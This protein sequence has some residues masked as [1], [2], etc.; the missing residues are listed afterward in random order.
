VT[1]LPTRFR[2]QAEQCAL[3]GSP[4]TA[5][6]LHGAA[7]AYDAG[8]P[9]RE[10]LL[11]LADDPSG[12]VPSLRF[13]GALHREV[14]SGHAPELAAHYPSAGGSAGIEGA[15]PAAQRLVEQR[16]DE[17]SGHLGRPV[18][19]NEV[20]RAAALYGGL[21]HVAAEHRLPVR[22]LEIGASAGLNLRPERFGYLLAG[23]RALGDPASPVVLHDP[24]RG[25]LPPYDTALDIL[26]RAGCDTAPLDAA[27]A[28]DQLTLLSYV[29]PDQLDRIDRLRGALQ[30]A[31]RDP[32]AVQR[33]S[34]SAF[35]RS[36]LADPVPGAATVVW[37]SVVRQYLSPDERADV[38]A[39]LAVAG[40]RATSDAPLVRLSLEPEKK[41]QSTF[42][43][44][45]EATT[46]P[47][48]RTRLLAECL[49][50]GPPVT[51]L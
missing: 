38:D 34:A 13:A 48:G 8:G 44:L 21:L 40:E 28:D 37:H 10:L 36:E 33:L 1:D 29:W 11:P 15:W 26:A 25:T 9:V 32:I 18:Q 6:L 12:S 24:W 4:L 7:T 17:L 51:W 3:H 2:A 42:R 47:G 23:G 50:H 5:A 39:V 14:L 27:D 16:Y 22:L 35:L 49:G 20:G 31:V 30:L 46:W 19:T 41:V 45:V 43:F